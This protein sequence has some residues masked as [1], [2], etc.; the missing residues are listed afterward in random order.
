MGKGQIAIFV[1]SPNL[2][3]ALNPDSAQ[4]IEHKRQNTINPNPSAF[5]RALGPMIFIV[6]SP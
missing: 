2:L 6:S 5:E 4:L 3:L 1:I